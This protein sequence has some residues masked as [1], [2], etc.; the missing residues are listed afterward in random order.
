VLELL[1]PP[2]RKYVLAV[3]PGEGATG[4]SLRDALSQLMH[5]RDAWLRACSIYFAAGNAQYTESVRDALED[6]DVVVRETAAFVL[7]REEIA[8]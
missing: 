4:D 3:P 5:G 2:T 8:C 7:S 1:E 6:Q